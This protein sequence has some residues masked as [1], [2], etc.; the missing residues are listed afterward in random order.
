[1]KTALS[2]LGA[3]ALLMIALHVYRGGNVTAALA[4]TPTGDPTPTVT[5]LPRSDCQEETPDEGDDGSDR[6][7]D[8]K[9]P[10][11]DAEE[12]QGSDSVGVRVE[13]RDWDGTD[14]DTETDDCWGPRYGISCNGQVMSA[15]GIYYF[16]DA[17]YQGQCA[18]YGT[19]SGFI[20][21][22]N[23]LV[24][25]FK[26]VGYENVELCHDSFWNGGCV[27]FYDD[28]PDLSDDGL[29]FGNGHPSNVSSHR[30]NVCVVDVLACGGAGDGDNPNPEPVNTNTADANCDGGVDGTDA[31]AVLSFASGA[32]N[33]CTGSGRHGDADC[34]GNVDTTDA[35]QI[36]LVATG[37]E[38]A[39]C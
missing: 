28:D 15:P 26:L 37:F 27:V 33:G 3:I 17:N 13:E 1:M 21:P 6:E 5:V 35:T 30:F 18:Y 11:D 29:D 10:R 32:G 36:L 38:T 25:S 2:F 39:A 23:D 31:L 19:D 9:G 7:D 16:F 8:D 14:P 22:E 4:G 24:S 34:S 20:A 12:E